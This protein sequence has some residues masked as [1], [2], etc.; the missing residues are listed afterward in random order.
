LQITK[1]LA[2]LK[3]NYQ[4]LKA[5]ESLDVKPFQGKIKPPIDKI[6]FINRWLWFWWRWWESNPRPKAFP[7]EFLR[8]Q[9]VVFCFASII[10]GQ[11]AIIFAIL[12][13]L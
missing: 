1:T 8:A 13:V 5:P 12:L 3:C 7:Q 2:D 11:Q 4:P 10:A 6:L 9:L